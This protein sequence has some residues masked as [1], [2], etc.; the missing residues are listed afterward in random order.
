VFEDPIDAELV[1]YV[2]RRA[3]GV[4]LGDWVLGNADREGVQTIYEDCL[5]FLAAFGVWGSARVSTKTLGRN[6]QRGMI[7][8]ISKSVNRLRVPRQAQE[9][10][11]AGFGRVL[12]SRITAV[13]KKDAHCANWL[14]ADQDLVMIDLEARTRLP[15]LYEVV[16]L[17]EDYPI[18]PADK[19]GWNRRLTLARM[20]LSELER[21]GLPGDLAGFEIAELY[22]WFVLAQAPAALNRLRKAGRETVSSS[23]QARALDRQAHLTALL[24]HLSS[25]GVVSDAQAYVAGAL[26]DAAEASPR[27]P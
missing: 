8:Q 10:L 21:Q 9:C 13:T 19:D 24:R 12:G 15:V 18:F 7:G 3:E 4:P 5:A 1:V 27:R 6:R 25:T 14:V 23:G 26:A 2:M 17:V 22:G 11:A 20:Y 16:Q